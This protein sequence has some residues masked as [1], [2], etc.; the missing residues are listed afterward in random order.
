MGPSLGP[1]S[2]PFLLCGTHRVLHTL[3]CTYLLGIGADAADEE[4]LGLAQCLQQFVKRCLEEE[5]M[6]MGL[7]TSCVAHW[8][9]PGHR[10]CMKLTKG[11]AAPAVGE[12]MADQR[13]FWG[14]GTTPLL[15]CRGEAVESRPQCIGLGGE[16]GG[17][18]C[19]P[20]LPLSVSAGL[21]LNTSRASTLPTLHP[22]T[23]S[24]DQQRALGSIPSIIRTKM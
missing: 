11:F 20:F 7:L 18:C 5:G 10:C 16:Y 3:A 21:G 8:G 17:S 15:F 22:H 23:S 9:G 2:E 24:T 14:W 6:L 19:L 1:R 4:G 13:L 12:L